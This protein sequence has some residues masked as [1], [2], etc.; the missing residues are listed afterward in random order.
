MQPRGIRNNNPLNIRR[1]ATKWQG[2]M[3]TQTDPDFCQF[4]SLEYGWRATFRLLTRNYFAKYGLDTIRKIVS[5]WA[6]PSEND[7]AAYIASVSRIIGIPPDETLGNPRE[8]PAH[9]LMLGAA[10][11][12]QE[13]GQNTLNYMAMLRGYEMAQ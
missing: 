9:W 6:P 2:M 5:R 13:N 10:M 7:T 4:Q 12:I 1:T 3:L 11:A 8:H